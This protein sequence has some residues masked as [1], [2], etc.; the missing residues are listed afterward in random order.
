MTVIVGDI[1]EARGSNPKKHKKAVKKCSKIKPG[2]YIFILGLAQA[3]FLSTTWLLFCVFLSYCPAPRQCH[4]RSL[5]FTAPL[6]DFPSPSKWYHFNGMFCSKKVP[7]DFLGAL[8]LSKSQ[9]DHFPCKTNLWKMT[10]LLRTGQ[11]LL[12]VSAEWQWRL[13]TL[14]KRGFRVRW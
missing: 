3:L 11:N 4:R 9:K 8:S 1:V 13:V 14:S 5:S 7:F 12:D 6:A 2:L 10:P